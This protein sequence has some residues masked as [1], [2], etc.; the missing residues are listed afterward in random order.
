MPSITYFPHDLYVLG[1]SHLPADPICDCNRGHVDRA[2]CAAYTASTARSSVPRGPTSTPVR[3]ANAHLH[4]QPPY[5]SS[6]PTHPHSHLGSQCPRLQVGVRG[7]NGILPLQPH[8]HDASRATNVPG[9][10]G[11]ARAPTHHP[12][13]LNSAA[14]QG[15]QAVSSNT[16]RGPLVPRL[17]PLRSI[18]VIPTDGTTNEPVTLF[19]APWGYQASRPSTDATQEAGTKAQTS[20]TTHVAGVRAPQDASSYDPP[21]VAPAVVNS[22]RSNTYGEVPPAIRRCR[23]ILGEFPQVIHTPHALL[24]PL[25]PGTRP[26]STPLHVGPL[27]AGP[28]S[29]PDA[30]PTSG[31]DDRHTNN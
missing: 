20:D 6:R 27:G 3:R 31:S 13:Q 28:S 5:P 15:H 10:S 23:M 25:H 21:S 16:T 11:L 7:P 14:I 29:V 19:R 9:F 12:I 18:T 8:N 24:V 30:T 2:D 17:V 4:S 22:T 26:L 1:W